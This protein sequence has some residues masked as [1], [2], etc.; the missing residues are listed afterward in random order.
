[1]WV[2]SR[3]FDALSGALTWYRSGNAKVSG[4]I[5][6]CYLGSVGMKAGD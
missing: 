6:Q 4:A 2:S 5:K 3:N 1:M